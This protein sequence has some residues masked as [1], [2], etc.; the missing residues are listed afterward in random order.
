MSRRPDDETP[1][2]PGGRAARRL[3]D[4]MERRAMADDDDVDVPSGADE[5][6]ETED[7]SSEKNDDP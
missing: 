6:A 4:F 5:D 1:D 3:H 2:P 7:D